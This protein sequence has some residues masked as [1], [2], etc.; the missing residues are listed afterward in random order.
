MFIYKVMLMTYLV[1]AIRSEDKYRGRWR[2]DEFNQHW[3]GNPVRSAEVEDMLAACKN[4]DGEAE[5]T[6]SKAMS[7]QDMERLYEF[8][9]QSRPKVDDD[10]DPGLKDVAAR[11]ADLF[12]NALASTGFTIWTRYYLAYVYCDLVN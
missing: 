12:F 2:F 6:H 1:S 3:I 10:N 8:S 9:Q 4:K 5:R 11:G 7:I